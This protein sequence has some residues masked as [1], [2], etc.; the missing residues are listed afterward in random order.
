M[1]RLPSLQRSNLDEPGRALW[2]LV[3]ATRAIS[4]VNAE[5]GLGGPFNPWLHA[6][7]V[8][9]RAA[10]LGTS[11]RFGTSIE[12]RLLE[13]AIIVVAA[14]W[15]AEFEWWAHARMARENGIAE[16]AIAAIRRDE[17]PPFESADEAI[18]YAVSRQLVA[19]GRIDDG[20]YERAVG[21]LGRQGVV[22]LVMLCGY[23]SMVSFTLNAFEVPLPPRVAPAWPS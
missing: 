11:V 23:Y 21:L 1:N 7:D 8:G 12:R 6:P 22:E 20:N 16:G 5:R 10:E 15:R 3:V 13:L 17:A 2:D 19:D 18:V 14:R 4:I 9:I